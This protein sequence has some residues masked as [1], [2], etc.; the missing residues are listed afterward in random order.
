MIVVLNTKH[1]YYINNIDRDFVAEVF[2]VFFLATSIN[3][4]N[5]FVLI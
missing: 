1:Y 5:Y 3:W 2:F 4:Y